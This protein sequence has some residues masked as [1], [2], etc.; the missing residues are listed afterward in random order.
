MSEVQAETKAKKE[1]KYVLEA[2]KTEGGK[3]AV[4]VNMD[5]KSHVFE[6]DHTH[7]LYEHFAVHGV[8]KKVRD[9]LAT[10][11]EPEKRHQA[12]QDLFAGFAEGKWN[13]HR[14]G[15][16]SSQVGILAR[17][18]SALYGRPVEEAQAFVAKLSKKQQADLRKH[19]DVAAK[20]I[21]LQSAEGDGKEA[22]D[23]LG[24]F[25]SAE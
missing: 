11:K 20:I 23:L 9:T 21:E 5:D 14:T 24:Q 16:G 10:V 22:E 12:V 19:K 8:G 15:D 6:F 3:L 13:P 7:P 25:A 1:P 2:G 4:T 18:M 17:A